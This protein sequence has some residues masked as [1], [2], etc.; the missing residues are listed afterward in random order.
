MAAAAD[1]C[2]VVITAASSFESRL[3]SVSPVISARDARDLRWFFGTGGLDVFASSTFGAQLE[4]A[5]LFY[6]GGAKCRRCRGTGFVP[7]NA[8]RWRKTTQLERELQRFVGQKARYLER[9]FADRVC[10]VCDGT[11]WRARRRRASARAAL[12]ARPRFAGNGGAGGSKPLGVSGAAV[13]V[14]DINLERLGRV[15]GRLARVRVHSAIS[16][17]VLGSYYAPEGAQRF[18]IWHLT[19]AGKTLG[20]KNPQ[21][22]ALSVL[23]ANEVAADR[24]KSDP[25]RRALID[26]AGVQAAQLIDR[27]HRL[28]NLVA[29][30]R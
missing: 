14:G 25:R 5:A 26:T 1:F 21:G 15:E 28:W 12:T 4:R 6:S 24:E 8:R 3:E 30:S 27:A 10:A 29:V 11:G 23:F 17:E 19:P 7:Q 18:S 13:D 22:L 9:P 2:Q 20:R 16:V